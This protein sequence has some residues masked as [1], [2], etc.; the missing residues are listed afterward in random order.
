MEKGTLTIDPNAKHSVIGSRQV[1]I[2]HFQKHGVCL[3][4]RAQGA[5]LFYRDVETGKR[6][7]KTWQRIKLKK[8]EEAQR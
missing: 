2:R 4:I 6:R 3:W 8:K 7:Q 5:T 1:A